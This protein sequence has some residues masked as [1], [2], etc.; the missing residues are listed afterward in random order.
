M[1]MGDYG[2]AE[3][4]LFILSK[5]SDN[6][7]GYTVKE[8]HEILKKEGV[9][10]HE[11]TVTRD[12]DDLTMQFFITED[13]RD[14][15]PVFYAEKYNLKNVDFTMAE[16]ISLYFGKEILSHYDSLDV[17]KNAIQI[18]NKLIGAA[19]PL[20]KKFINELNDNLKVSVS[21]I[22]QEKELNVEYLDTIRHSIE[23]QNKIKI[24]YYSFN[25]DCIS[26]RIV[27]PYFLEVNEGCYHL[28]GYCHLRKA[29]RDF[30]VSRIKGIEV[31]KDKF[32]KPENFYE[33]YQRNRFNN[34][35]SDDYIKLKLQFNEEAGRYIK[36]YE[37]EKADYIQDNQKG[38]YFERRVTMSDEII[39]WI[40]SYGASVKVIEPEYLGV[41]IK[42]EIEK[43]TNLYK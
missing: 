20:E 36:E 6:C 25:S 1:V 31:L 33:R 32:E 10:V 42:D 14:G 8:M 35:C 29:I 30:R 16:L 17:G 15:K 38:L 23:T 12:I 21:G 28:I 27:E 22:N 7:R 19:P 43:M 37:L 13:V 11:K 40:L 3:R 9:D 41:K 34:L 26:T 39:K 18:I 2:Q 4:Q 24:D 5:L